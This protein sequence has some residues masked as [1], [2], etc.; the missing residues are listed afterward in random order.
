MAARKTI[1]SRKIVKAR[2]A[3]APKP[4]AARSVFL[5][6]LGAVAM[7]RKQG[8]KLYAQLNEEGRALR[9]NGIKLVRDTRKQ[10]QTQIS[11]TLAPVKKQVDAK[12][13]EVGA[14]VEQGVGRALS[15]L[16]VPSKADIEDLTQR[17]GALSRQLRAATK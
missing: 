17:V 15:R 3:V 11:R 6:G 13:A 14:A 9:A 12:A 10:V 1:K 16:G 7:T 4:D 2:K 5:A 8:D